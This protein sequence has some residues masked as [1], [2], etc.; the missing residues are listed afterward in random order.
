MVSGTF[1]AGEFVFSDGLWYKATET[2]YAD[3]IS[4]KP[5]TLSSTVVDEFSRCG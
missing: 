2:G 3:V 4:G 1:N 5:H